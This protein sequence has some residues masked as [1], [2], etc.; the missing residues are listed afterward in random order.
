MVGTATIVFHK[1]SMQTKRVE[2]LKMYSFLYPLYEKTRVKYIIHYTSYIY[3]GQQSQTNGQHCKLPFKNV[4][5]TV[6]D[7]TIIKQNGYI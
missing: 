6:R 7:N 3:D 1:S 4:H 5:I 2:V